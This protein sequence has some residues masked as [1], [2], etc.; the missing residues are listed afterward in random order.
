MIALGKPTVVFLLNG[1]MVAVDELVNQ[2]NVALVE[3][4]YP[5]MEGAQAL[6]ES[7]FGQ[8]NKWGKMPYTIYPASWAS[9]NS[10]LEHD[11]VS[12]HRTYR[13]GAEAVVPF[14][15]GIS[16]TRFTLSAATPTPTFQAVTGSHQVMEA[17][18][19]VQNVGELP[20]DEVVMAYLHPK[21]VSLLT[22]PVKTLFDF[23]R[24]NHLVPGES[25]NATFRFEAGSFLLP[26]QDGNLLSVPGDY[27]LSFE[28]G[29]GQ[30]VQTGL[31]INGEA[32]VV[33]P[34]PSPKRPESAIK[35]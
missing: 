18:I 6:A 26:D 17:E 23:Q 15:A 14:G 29:A 13:Y 7:L 3:A 16:L 30:V 2:S 11:L 32:T 1:G 25:R 28:N 20:G 34:F 12:S 31:K 8:A 5:G 27:W 21:N 4:F 24:L 22:Y 9:R 33:E 19:T 10:M 35:L